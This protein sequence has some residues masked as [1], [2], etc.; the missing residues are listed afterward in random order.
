MP[1]GIGIVKGFWYFRPAIVELRNLRCLL[2]FKNLNQ[3][4]AEQLVLQDLQEQ[5]TLTRV[6]QSV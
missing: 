2:P 3:H 4:S 5:Q 1:G 6:V